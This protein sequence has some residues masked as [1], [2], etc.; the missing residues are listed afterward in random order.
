MSSESPGVTC[1]VL[2]LQVAAAQRGE[3]EAW[4]GQKQEDRSKVGM[5]HDEFQIPGKH[6]FKHKS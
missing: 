5:Q 4:W 3:H 2:A 1:A 6:E